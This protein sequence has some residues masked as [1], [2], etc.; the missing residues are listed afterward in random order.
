[1]EHV[2]LVAFTVAADSMEEA[3]ARLT[4]ALPDVAALTYVESWWIAEDERYD[5]SD[6]DSAVFVPMGRQHQIMTMLDE[7]RHL[8]RPVTDSQ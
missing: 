2:I 4:D 7:T 6:N 1:M 3:Q 5:L 8:G